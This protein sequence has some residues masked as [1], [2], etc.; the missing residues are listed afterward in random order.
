MAKEKGS[1][2]LIEDDK[3]WADGYKYD[4]QEFVDFPII[5]EIPPRNLSDLRELVLQH[6]AIAVVLDEKLQ[7]GSDAAYLG[8]DALDFLRKEFANI[9]VALVTQYPNEPEL[10]SLPHGMILAKR[11]VHLLL[12]WLRS[13]TQEKK[14]LPAMS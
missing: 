10:R 1:I 9:P 7:Q 14:I 4:I 13:W 12:L 5:H 8:I 2:L 6:N 11:D 3:D